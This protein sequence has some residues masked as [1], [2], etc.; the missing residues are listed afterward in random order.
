MNA[1]NKKLI[2]L[3]ALVLCL[4][5]SCSGA[6]AATANASIVASETAKITAPFSG[7]LLPFDLAAGE[8]VAEG[9]LLFSLDTTPVYAAE[10]GTVAAVFAAEGDDASGVMNH[11]GALAVIEPEYPLYIDANTDDAHDDDDNRYIHAGETL[12]LKC[13]DEKGKGIVTQVNGKYYT[14]QVLEGDF[15]LNDT[16]R[17]Y[18]E[19]AMP[20]DSET[21]RGKAKR[22]ADI[23]VAASG[24][25]T[26]VHVQ[27]GDKVSTGDLLFETVD[28]MSAKDAS[29]DIAAP[30]SGA[31]TALYAA[32]GAQ[33]YRGQLLC[34]IADLSSL[35]LS[36]EIDEIDVVSL[37][38]GDALTY[39]LDAY[40]DRTFTGI[41]TEIRP[42]G[43]A[44]QNASY[45]DVR[46]TAP[47]GA[48]ILPGM[49]A[50]IILQ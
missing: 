22:Y 26:R 49:N 12:Y 29:A 41:V 44:R 10:N 15:D 24:R 20:Y 3:T 46:I 38:V 7:T 47:D 48:A 39:T 4:S 35:E 33:V 18:R 31:V 28:A 19:S 34:E 5:V 50:T 45:F 1:M 42:V 36:A 37:R 16:V 43:M 23:A 14:V 11:Y 8:S 25:V 13:G 30:V 17:C 40:A 6:L 21:G 2:L 32:S 9:D 27:P